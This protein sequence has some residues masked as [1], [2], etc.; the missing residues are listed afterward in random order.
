MKNKLEI[1]IEHD[2]CVS[3]PIYKVED[4]YTLYMRTRNRKVAESCY[5]NLKLE[6]Q[7]EKENARK[8]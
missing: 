7:R 4:A 5:K 2:G 8:V 1:N 6:Y 3:D